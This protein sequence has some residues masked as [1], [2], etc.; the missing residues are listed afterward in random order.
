MSTLL[1][2]E[3]SGAVG[4]L[5]LRRDVTVHERSIASPRDQAEQL[6]PLIA[7]LLRAADV[8]IA[9]IEGIVFGRGPGSF[10]GLRI[11]TAIAQGLALAA[12]KP[13]IGISSLAAVAQHAL[14]ANG[15]ERSLVCI[16][17]RMDEVYFGAFEAEHGLVRGRGPERVATP[18]EVAVPEWPRWTALGGGFA[19]YPSVLA[20]VARRA[21]AVVADI[22]PRARDL[23]RLA[24]RELAEGGAVAATA[25]R[26]TYLRDDSAWRRADRDEGLTKL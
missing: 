3:T 2:I 9:Q 13:V 11:A 1:A 23:M 19:A 24:E 16:D 22:S 25:A 14:D 6:L 4:S 20:S 21:E 8:T 5:A 12:Q 10:T 26:P 17:A 15:I 7:E 18:E